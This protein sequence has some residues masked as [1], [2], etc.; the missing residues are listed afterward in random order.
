MV[1]GTVA[2]IVSLVV[3]LQLFFSYEVQTLKVRIVKG[4]AWSNSFADD[5][6][7]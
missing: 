2:G 6:P 1:A 4:G 5:K 7:K 3:S